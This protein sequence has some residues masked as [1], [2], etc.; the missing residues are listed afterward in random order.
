MANHY[1]WHHLHKILQHSNNHHWS[2]YSYHLLHLLP[3][4]SFP[5]TFFHHYQP[6]T[7]LYALTFN[8][9]PPPFPLSSQER[10]L[11]IITH[12]IN[13]ISKTSKQNN[14]IQ[15]TL[16]IVY[17]EEKSQ[18]IRTEPKLS[19]NSH[20][21]MI[22]SS[23]QNLKVLVLWVFFLICFSTISFPL[24]MGPGLTLKCLTISPS[25]E[26]PFHIGTLP[27]KHEYL[28]NSSLVSSFT[29]L[30]GTYLPETFVRK[31]FDTGIKLYLFKSQIMDSEFS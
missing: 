26:S 16:K 15:I 21:E 12:P 24:N 27:L 10:Q 1:Q 11:C 7:L 29:H 18:T 22:S 19:Q 13:H 2:S 14:H 31:T 23:T 28:T 4:S 30:Y 20:K 6:S 8:A 9:L 25:S 3:H 5:W 17:I